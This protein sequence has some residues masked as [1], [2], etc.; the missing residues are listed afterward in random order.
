MYF[1]VIATR[2]SGLYE[3]IVSLVSNAALARV[4]GWRTLDDMPGTLRCRVKRVLQTRPEVFEV[5]KVWG[6][7]GAER[8]KP[9]SAAGMMP[10]PF[11]TV[12]LE[13]YTSAICRPKQ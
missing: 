6:R 13:T 3:W 11:R 10:E 5:V 4:V 7:V 1:V 12:Y 9:V 2:R 8:G